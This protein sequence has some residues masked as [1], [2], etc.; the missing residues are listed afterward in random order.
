MAAKTY[1][2]NV[3]SCNILEIQQET[4]SKLQLLRCVL[5]SNLTGIAIP[6][7]KLKYYLKKYT[8]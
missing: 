8:F 4:D 5:S 7:F 2:D 6:S 1:S 3:V